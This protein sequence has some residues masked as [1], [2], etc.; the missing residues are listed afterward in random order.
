M[1]TDINEKLNGMGLLGPIAAASRSV[2]HD[3]FLIP[4][5]SVWNTREGEWQARKRKW[6]ALGMRSEE[7]REDNMTFSAK[8]NEYR[9]AP[10]GVA[11]TSV[12]DPNVCELCYK[13][14]APPEG[15]ILDPFAGG[16]VR[17]IVASVM[18]FKYWGN[19]LSARQITANIEQI[20]E[21]TTGKYKPKWHQGDS[22]V[23]MADAPKA[24]FLF[25]CPPYGDLEV[26]SDAPE[27]ISNKEYDE[28]LVTYREIIRL[29]AAKLR[30]NRFAGW[31]VANFRDKET[32][33]IHNFVGDTVDAFEDAG[34]SFYNDIILV[35]CAGSAPLRANN[36]FIRGNRKVVKLHQNVLIF[37]KGDPK[38]AQER[39]NKNNHT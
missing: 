14:F 21:L 3:K 25:S 1:A 2:L 16:S 4:P 7:G 22:L 31:V 27:D 37:C 8:L 15:V 34:C 38:K 5:F 36:T 23:K 20:N 29:A 11:Q 17:G 24:D 9:K 30:N 10:S 18:D 13:W 28:F 35:N 6:R 33:R 39:I 26:Y 32:G 19:D 12:F